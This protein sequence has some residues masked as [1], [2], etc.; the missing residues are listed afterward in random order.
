MLV[1]LMAA[2]SV[3]V[4]EGDYIAVALRKCLALSAA[5]VTISSFLSLIPPK[6]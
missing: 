2:S 1:K 3:R 4:E 5:F 6:G